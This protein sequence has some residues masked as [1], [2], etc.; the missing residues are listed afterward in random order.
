MAIIAPLLL[1]LRNYK[2]IKHLITPGLITSAFLSSLFLIFRKFPPVCS[3]L[4]SDKDEDSCEFQWKEGELYMCLMCV[5]MIKNRSAVS[6]EQMVETFLTYSKI[7]NTV[8]FFR[9][10]PRFGFVYVLLCFIRL[11]ILPDVF[12]EESD[13]ILHVDDNTI[14][15]VMREDSK[16]VWVIEFFTTWSPQC[17]SVAPVIASLAKEYTTDFLR[18][19]K[20]DVGRYPDAATKYGVSTSSMSRQLPTLI[21]FKDFKPVNW[22]PMIGK[23]NKFIKYSFTE[24]NVIRDFCLNTLYEESK[25]KGK[26][27]K[28]K[29]E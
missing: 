4:P 27:Q 17:H 7:V 28:K 10:D 8:L 14:E 21:V 26:K 13:E 1:L 25:K 15:Q 18:F 9:I 3:R 20:I 6:L 16:V 19:A 2:S 22:R 24:E 12:I 29:V 5:V 11:W 23:N